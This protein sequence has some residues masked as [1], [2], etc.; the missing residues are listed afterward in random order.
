M[1]SKPQ[2]LELHQAAKHSLSELGDGDSGKNVVQI[3]FHSGW[4]GVKPPLVHRIL[5]IHNSPKTLAQFEEYREAV[6]SRAARS[7]GASN[8]RCIADGNERLRFYCSTAMCAVG[9]GGGPGEGAPAGPPVGACGSQYCCTC[10]IVRHGF[11]GKRVDLDG[12]ATHATGWGAHVS[13]PEELEREFAFLQVRR[14]V[15][16]CRVVA[17]RVARGGEEA[18][19]E[20]KGAVFDSFVPIG[21]KGGYVEEEEELLVFNPRAVLPC[22]VIVYSA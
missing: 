18:E 21:R 15:L 1:M 6:R 5:K 7:R 10:G 17:G 20:K 2:L 19:E 12:I 9:R 11:A 8:E 13:L 4:R 16:V 3:I 14:V 22:F